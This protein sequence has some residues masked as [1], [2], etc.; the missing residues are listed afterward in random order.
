MGTKL[1]SLIM[2]NPLSKALGWV[3]R[4][5]FIGLI[6][7]Y[8]YTISP[9]LQNSC[10]YTPSCSVYA[11]DALKTHGALKGG[12]LA[13]KRILSCNPWGGHGD[14]PVPPKGSNILNL[15]QIKNHKIHHE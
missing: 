14:D 9:L 6:K 1:K 13:A 15:R 7:L 5:I 4:M 10:R 12:Y 3:F 11:I 2:E 8:Q